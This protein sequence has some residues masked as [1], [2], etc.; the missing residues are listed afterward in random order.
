MF[1]PEVMA[2]DVDEGQLGVPFELGPEFI[3]VDLPYR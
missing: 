3:R 1:G 2:E